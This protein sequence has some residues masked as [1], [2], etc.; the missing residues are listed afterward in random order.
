MDSKWI[1]ILSA[2]GLILSPLISALGQLLQH[3][4]DTMRDAAE[5]IRIASEANKTDADSEKIRAEAKVLDSQADKDLVNFWISMVETLRNEVNNLTE[6]SRKNISEIAVLNAKLIQADQ[7]KAK[8]A[9]DNEALV[10]KVQE[11]SE[12]VEILRQK[13]RGE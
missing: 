1:V 3:K 10:K 8:L 9:R 2:L 7:E 12:E 13:L 4:R 5:K 11:L 6:L